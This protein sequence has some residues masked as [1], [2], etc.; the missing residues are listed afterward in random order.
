[1]QLYA[2]VISK[3]VL[4]TGLEKLVNLRVLYA[5]NNKLK[6]W[7]EVERLSTLP[8]SRGASADW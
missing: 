4:Q 2:V 7:P 6:D 1:M 8:K 5:S 3:G